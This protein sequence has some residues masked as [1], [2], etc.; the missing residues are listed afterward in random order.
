MLIWMIKNQRVCE[1]P[2]KKQLAYKRRNKSKVGVE[3]KHK[4]YLR[5]HLNTPE[6]WVLCNQE[7]HGPQKLEWD[8]KKTETLFQTTG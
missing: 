7:R 2:M 6:I 8:L 4:T 1:N 3:N 5:L